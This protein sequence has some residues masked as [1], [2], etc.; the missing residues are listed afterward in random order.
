M[1]VME[2]LLL[3]PDEPGTALGAEPGIPATSPGPTPAPAPAATAPVVCTAATELS[4]FRF[5]PCCCAV[6]ARDAVGS[7]SSSGRIK[8]YTL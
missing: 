1:G 8:W 5:A 4:A 6:T 2:E 7:K 3:P